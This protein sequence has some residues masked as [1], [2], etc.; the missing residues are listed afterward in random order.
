MYALNPLLVC[1]FSAE[2]VTVNVCVCVCVYLGMHVVCVATWTLF[3]CSMYVCAFVLYQQKL[4]YMYMY[5]N[6]KNGEH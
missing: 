3:P 5:L 6:K 4:T 2:S 1:V